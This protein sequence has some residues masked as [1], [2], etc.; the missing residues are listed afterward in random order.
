MRVLCV[1]I[2]WFWLFNLYGDMITACFWSVFRLE[3]KT[4]EEKVLNIYIICFASEIFLLKP[5]TTS[6][7]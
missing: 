4:D 3:A 6:T 2:L 7:L 5:K 1:R